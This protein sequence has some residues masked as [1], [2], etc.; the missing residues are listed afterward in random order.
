M[1]SLGLHFIKLIVLAVIVFGCSQEEQKVTSK[2]MT[3][4]MQIEGMV[5]EMGCAM[6]IEEKLAEAKGVLSA[7]VNYEEATCNVEFDESQ[8][9]EKEIISLIQSVN[10]KDHYKVE[11]FKATGVEAGSSTAGPNTQEAAEKESVIDRIP[12][13]NFPNI[14]GILRRV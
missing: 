14:F 6:S 1:K 7:E 11:G 5:C 3:A 10:G 9:S 13:L 12:R 2:V 8:V 4:S